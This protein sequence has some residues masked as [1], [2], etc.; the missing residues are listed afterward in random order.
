MRI[1]GLLGFLL[2]G[3]SAAY[4]QSAQD[5]IQLNREAIETQKNFLVS[6]NMGIQGSGLGSLAAPLDAH[7]DVFV[8]GGL[9]AAS[10]YDPASLPA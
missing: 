9:L 10:V 2:M 6:G 5:V 7:D 3:G 1:A 8:H 4:S